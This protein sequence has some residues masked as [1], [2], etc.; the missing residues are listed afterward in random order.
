MQTE[1]RTV[2]LTFQIGEVS[3]PVSGVVLRHTIDELPTAE[4]SVQLGNMDQVT[5][6][7]QSSV[8]INTDTFRKAA[9]L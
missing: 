3:M 4:I 2:A 5:E 7:I 6:A 8:A 9:G 1:S